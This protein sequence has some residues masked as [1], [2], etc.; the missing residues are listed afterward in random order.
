MSE[1]FR[2]TVP[3]QSEPMPSAEGSSNESQEGNKAFETLKNLVEAGSLDIKL[4]LSPPRTGST[5]M[6]NSFSQNQAIDSHVHEPFI[7]GRTSA[8]QD[9]YQ[10]ILN[11]IQTPSADHEKESTLLVKEMSH[12]L[13][14]NGEHERMLPLIKSPV[15]FL[16]RN[17]L[18]NT[19]SRI[20]KVLESLHL[21]DKTAVEETLLNYYAISKGSTD[22]ETYLH[23]YA[24]V[25]DRDVDDE[26]IRI[27]RAN[28]HRSSVPD[29]PD[30]P[31]FPL[32]RWLLDYYAISK[33]HSRWKTMLEDE[34][35]NRNYKAFDELLQD[36]RVFG[37]ERTG[38]KATAELAHY[39]QDRGKEV[40]V[41]DS[42]DYRLDPETIVPALC[43][44]WDIPFSPKMIEWG[45]RGLGQYTQQTKPHQS[46][47]YDKLERSTHIEAPTEIS[48]VLADFPDFIAEHLVTIDLPAYVDVLRNFP[49]IDK[50]TESAAKTLDVPV[51][52]NIY[53]RLRDMDVL[54]PDMK[55]T[56]D[57]AC[58]EE[59]FTIL[60]DKNLLSY[61]SSQYESLHDAFKKGKATI[62]LPMDEID[63]VTAFLSS[64]ELLHDEEF[65]KRNHRYLP[66]LKELQRVLTD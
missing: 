1:K 3:T 13:M 7:T 39:L 61:S 48:P 5:L 46:I 27:Y 34:F 42:T 20:K 40:T 15:I 57:E 55:L 30:V 16:V 49:R 8:K 24:D 53:K 32:Q 10:T 12:W 47:W 11:A 66:T 19:E 4:I 41:V 6:E 64:P 59:V 9:G 65:R 58:D 25:A 23:A 36:E 51:A 31:T 17:P 56:D 38:W 28:K 45:E 2:G 52:R 37:I 62:V 14:A 22:W 60:S 44:K 50:N 21:R 29:E 43:K 18:L 54:P 33:G 63:P 35:N 26:A